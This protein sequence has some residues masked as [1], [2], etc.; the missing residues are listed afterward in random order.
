ME[1]N[2]VLDHSLNRSVTHPAYLMLRE[3]K[4][5]KSNQITVQLHKTFSA[6]TASVDRMIDR[7]GFNVLLYTL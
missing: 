1:K 7:G 3:L 4:R 6:K 2:R 5:I